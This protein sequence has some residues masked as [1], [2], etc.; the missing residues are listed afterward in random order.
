MKGNAYGH[1]LTLALTLASHHPAV[2]GICVE[3]LDEMYTLRAHGYEGPLMVSTHGYEP[4]VWDALCEGRAVGVL[5]SFEAIQA[6]VHRKR[7]SM[8]IPA[9]HIG[10]DTGI[11]R[12]GV[13]YDDMT[14]S[15]SLLTSAG[16]VCE[17]IMTH[18][19]HKDVDESVFTHE[20][21]MRFD[22][23]C[24]QACSILMPGAQ[25]HVLSSGALE[26]NNTYTYEAVRVGINVYGLYSSDTS[27]NRLEPQLAHPLRPALTWKARVA[28]CK[29]V[30][31]GEY[32]GYGQYHKATR[33]TRVAVVPVGYADGLFR[34]YAHTLYMRVRGHYAPVVGVVNMNLTLLDVTD[35]PAVCAGDE[36]LIMGDD[37]LV[38]AYSHAQAAQTIVYEIT[39]SIAH[40]VPR[41]S[42]DE[43]VGV[44]QTSHSELPDETVSHVV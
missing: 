42:V 32:V 28:Y 12:L 13:R 31:E 15:L 5:Q 23:V 20:Q 34:R 26:F 40:H 22:R 3:T 2:H 24:A 8:P 38:S 36:V 30:H 27:R 16:I 18:L 7:L 44:I 1:G 35:I 21:C 17:G 4:D 6:L 43:C 10:I 39:G 11:M 19:A 9:V 14:P 29:T 33:P 25:R 37:Q 41:V